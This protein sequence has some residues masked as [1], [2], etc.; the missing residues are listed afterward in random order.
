MDRAEHG[1]WC[2]VEGS[3]K[4]QVPEI[5]RGKTWVYMQALHALHTDLTPSAVPKE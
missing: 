1:R 2:G 4:V 5:R 3:N